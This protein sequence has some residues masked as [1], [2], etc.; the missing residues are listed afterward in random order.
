M[1]CCKCEDEA[2]QFHYNQGIEYAYCLKHG[3]K[4]HVIFND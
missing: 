1:R 4:C 3:I 2:V